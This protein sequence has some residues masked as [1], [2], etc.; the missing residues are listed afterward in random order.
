VFEIGKLF[1]LTHVVSDLDAVD[2]WYDDVFSVTRFYKGY[3][4]LAGRDASLI[5]LAD[6]VLE[7]MTPAR[8]RELKN[9]SVKRFHDRFGE[10]FHSIAW[11]VDDVTALSE[12]LA[13]HGLRQFNLV[14][15]EVTPPHSATAI[16][17]HP[18]QTFGQLEFALPGDFIGDPRFDADWSAEPWRE[19]PLGIERTSHVGVVVRDLDAATRLYCDV[20]GGTLF[21]TDEVPERARRAYVA[22]GEDSVVELA[23]PL[24]PTSREGRDLDHNGEGIHS[25]VF[26]TADLDRASAF[27]VDQGLTPER[28]DDD[29]VVLGPDQAFGMVVGFTRRALPGDPR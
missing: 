18:K 19:H 22:I 27:L 24:D 12:R 2:R 5:A 17:T 29:T 14:G 16:W 15:R 21:H 6:L 9:L 26:R 8:D 3:E 20:L 28:D 10:H 25:L 23:L 4:E 11:Y 7:P 13:E 1:H